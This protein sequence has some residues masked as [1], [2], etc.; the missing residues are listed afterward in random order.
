MRCP[1]CVVRETISMRETL[2]QRLPLL[3]QGMPRTGSPASQVALQQCQKLSELMLPLRWGGGG[4]LA[5][6]W[7]SR[8]E[9][10]VGSLKQEAKKRQRG[11]KPGR[12][13]LDAD[14]EQRAGSCHQ[15]F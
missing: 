15:N 11:L 10:Q 14:L 4:C 9:S 12:G 8:Q 7:V 1:L 3:G 6:G 13:S 2:S 5:G